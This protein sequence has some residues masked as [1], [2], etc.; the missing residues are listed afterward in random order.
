MCN[1]LVVWLQTCLG[2]RERRQRQRERGTKRPSTYV[3]LSDLDF[4]DHSGM[5]R[6]IFFLLL[7]I[8]FDCQL[9]KFLVNMD[10]LRF[11]LSKVAVV[12]VIS[13]SL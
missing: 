2:K 4:H 1:E 13:F 7:T 11:C 6:Q 8:K 9:S 3:P 12:V 10:Y 5:D